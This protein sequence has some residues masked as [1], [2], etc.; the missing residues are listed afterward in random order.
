[1]ASPQTLRGLHD[2]QLQPPLRSLLCSMTVRFRDWLGMVMDL[3]PKEGMQVKLPFGQVYRTYIL[4][5]Y[6]IFDSERADHQV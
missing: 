6:N 1:M 5:I 2:A 4:Y 3:H